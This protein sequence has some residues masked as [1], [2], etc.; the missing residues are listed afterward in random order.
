MDNMGNNCWRK[1]CMQWNGVVEHIWK[2]WEKNMKVENIIIK[3]TK[4]NHEKSKTVHL[5]S[6]RSKN[7]EKNF[8]LCGSMDGPQEHYAK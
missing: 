4:L 8:S 6:N 1:A 2:I 5:I 3:K 7:S